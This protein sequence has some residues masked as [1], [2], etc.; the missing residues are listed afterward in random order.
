MTSGYLLQLFDPGPLRVAVIER[1]LVCLSGKPNGRGEKAVFGGRFSLKFSHRDARGR[2][3][4]QAR[5]RW[6]KRL[7]LRRH[8]KAIRLMC[9]AYRRETMLM[10]TGNRKGPTREE[11]AGQWGVPVTRRVGAGH[12]GS[13]HLTRMS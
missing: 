1:L 13:R 2:K 10:E 8:K 5:S 7:T 9:P 6:P 12:P 4:R 11:K 3:C